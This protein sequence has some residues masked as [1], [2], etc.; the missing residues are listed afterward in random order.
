MRVGPCCGLPHVVACFDGN[1]DLALNEVVDGTRRVGAGLELV[2]V[3]LFVLL[4]PA[5][6][7]AKVALIR[8]QAGARRRGAVFGGWR[9]QGHHVRVRHDAAGAAVI[10]DRARALALMALALARA[11]ARA[12]A[13]RA[14]SANAGDQ[15]R[16]EE[17]QRDVALEQRVS[18]RGIWVA[19]AGVLTRTTTERRSTG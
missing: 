1:G 10:L 8:V 15:E 16:E 2:Q 5:A 6:E 7:I 12:D 4:E 14:G 18:L 13:G 19:V 3:D 9:L 11:R 17:H